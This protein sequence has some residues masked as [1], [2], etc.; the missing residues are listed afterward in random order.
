MKRFSDWVLIKEGMLTPTT[1]PPN[2]IVRIYMTPGSNQFY[3]RAFDRYEQQTKGQMAILF[4]DKHGEYWTHHQNAE[5]GYGPLLYDLAIEYATKLGGGVLPATGQVMLSNLPFTN[6]DASAAVWN[7]YLKR[8]DVQHELPIR[9]EM[10][11]KSNPQI[12]EE[13]RKNPGLF[14][15]YRKPMTFINQLTKLGK[16]AFKEKGGA[17]W[18]KESKTIQSPLQPS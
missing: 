5:H 7:Q 4:M 1:L 13:F 18:G 17:S 6:T 16:L 12:A 15:V 8:S 2:V 3:I 9:L 14:Y 10:L 11:I